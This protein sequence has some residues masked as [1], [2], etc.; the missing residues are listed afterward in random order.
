VAAGKISC[1]TAN[2]R[3]WKAHQDIMLVNEPASPSTQE[4]RWP[5]ATHFIGDH[6]QWPENPFQVN[7]SLLHVD[8]I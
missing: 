5:L 6:E 1:L 8:I 3:H 2:I 4:G 7:M